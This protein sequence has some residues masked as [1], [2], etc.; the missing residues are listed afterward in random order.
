MRVMQRSWPKTNCETRLL[1]S[2]MPTSNSSCAA[3]LRAFCRASLGRRTSWT[4]ASP[5]TKR[6]S[7][8]EK[9]AVVYTVLNKQGSLAVDVFLHYR[10]E[11]AE[12]RE[13]ADAVLLDGRT[14]WISSKRDLI[15]AKQAIVPPRKV[16]TRDIEDLLELLGE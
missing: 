2:S 5:W 4:C 13:R 3:V 16:D 15:V 8:E 1:R 12:L 6:I 9:H 7:S 10:F 11:F 14:V